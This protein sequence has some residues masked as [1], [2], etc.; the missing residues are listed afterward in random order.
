MPK[1]KTHKASRKRVKVTATG[2]VLVW[3]VGGRHMMSGKR[4]KNRR[5]M[6]RARPLKS[7]DKR[8]VLRGL[9]RPVVEKPPGGQVESPTKEQ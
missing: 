5:H 9:V 4:S 3:P 6:R 7:T 1:L 8:R 2:K